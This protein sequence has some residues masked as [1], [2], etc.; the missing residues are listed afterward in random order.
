MSYILDALKRSEQ[1]RHQG[2]APNLADSGTLLHIDPRRSQLWPYLLIGVLMLNAVV[3]AFFQ[4]Q[5]GAETAPSLATERADSSN[6][7][8]KT[9]RRIEKAIEDSRP[10]IVVSKKVPQKAPKI[11]PKTSSRATEAGLLSLGSEGVTSN[12]VSELP[13]ADSGVTHRRD[14]IAE[15]VFKPGEGAVYIDGGLLIQPKKNR[16][17]LPVIA[18]ETVTDALAVELPKQAD[19]ESLSALN[20]SSASIDHYPYQYS[21]VPLL[22]EMDQHF[23]RKVP[24]MIFNSHIYSETPSARRVMINNNYLREGQMFSGLEVLEIGEDHLVLNRDG[25]LFKIPVL[26][27]WNGF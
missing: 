6:G 14:T 21:E 25:V 26:R 5:S 24:S 4:W 10:A 17:Q 9:K 1:E 16:S 12:V 13:A 18:N 2:Q 27:D 22:A 8:S 23:Q 3:Y 11:T 19:D 15:S 20:P 7:A